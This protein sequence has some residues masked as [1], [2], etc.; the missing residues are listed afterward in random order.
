MTAEDIVEKKEPK[1][2][3]VSFTGKQYAAG[4]SLCRCY[5]VTF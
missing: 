1:R 5:H 3:P 2:L 4:C